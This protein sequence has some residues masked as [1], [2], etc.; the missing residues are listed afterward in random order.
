MPLAY[1][2]VQLALYSPPPCYWQDVDRFPPPIH[3]IERIEHS[4]ESDGYYLGCSDAFDSRAAWLQCQA[5]LHPREWLEWHEA[6]IDQENRAEVW[7][8]LGRAKIYRLV[9]S[10]R[11][12]R[13]ELES[14]RQLIGEEAYFAGRMPSPVPVSES[15]R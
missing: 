3:P 11:C 15:L 2:L 6:I 12:C 7:R 1:L 13:E 5:A 10:P 8:T 9:G 14:L 4:E